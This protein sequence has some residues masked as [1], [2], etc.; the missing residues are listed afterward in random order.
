MGLKPVADEHQTGFSPDDWNG[1]IFGHNLH[2]CLV[3]TRVS[4]LKLWLFLS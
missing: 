3:V 4:C 1:T 2:Y